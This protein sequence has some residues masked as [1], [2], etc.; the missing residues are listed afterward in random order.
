MPAVHFTEPERQWLLRFAKAQRLPW[1]I[2]RLELECPIKR[3]LTI[4]PQDYP[5][6]LTM[7][8]QSSS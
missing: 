3:G 1:L 4:D 8:R 5:H 6:R 2:N 7:T